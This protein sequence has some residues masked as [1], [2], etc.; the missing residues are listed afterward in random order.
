[1]AN[2]NKKKL[3]GS[4]VDE[5][6][7]STG[8]WPRY[9]VMTATDEGKTL[10]KLSPFAIHKGVKG[11]AGGDVTIKRQFGGDIYLTCCKKSQSDNLLK[12]VLFG[13]VAPVVVTQ[14]KSLNT[15]KGV[16]RN[17]ELARTDPDE[18]KENVPS[19]LDVQRIIIKR[20][21]MEVKTN[22]LL[23]L[24]S[25]KIPDS[26]K[27]CY[28]NI[29][30]T[31]YV[32]NPLRCYKCQ[33]FG[34]VT[35]KCK[36]NETCAKCSETGHKDDSCTKA[37][38]CIN[39]GESHAAYSKK[40]AIFK[41][42]FDIQSIRV[43]RNISFFEARTVYQQTHGQKVVN[44]A[45]A[46][47]V[48]TQTA[49]VC[50]QTD[51]S[52]VGPEPVTRRQRPAASVTNRPVPSVSR[53]VGTTTRVADV[54]KTAAPARSSPAKKG[55][56]SSK[57]SSPKQQ[58]APVPESD[59]YF[60]I[61]TNRGKVKENSPIT[62][63][64]ISPIKFKES[65][66]KKERL[67]RS[68]QASDF[69]PDVEISPSRSDLIKNKVKKVDKNIMFSEIHKQRPR[70]DDFFGDVPQCSNQTDV[71]LTSASDLETNVKSRGKVKKNIIRLPVD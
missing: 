36:H 69:L 29:P 28:L 44:Y 53:S 23:T 4:H 8:P 47:R 42:E 21:N 6:G 58:S 49:S 26:L 65:M 38:K 71:S 67:K 17:W 46:V 14:H 66:L 70:A 18:I 2:I 30:V 7:T 40:C 27:I 19:I 45:G 32:P 37:F 3:D 15:S 13:N 33:R 51:V 1:M 50:T 24:N 62:N 20:N 41:R 22:T 54:K 48:P 35:S 9:L 5:L 59:A 10:S 31:Q 57:P 39:C 16:V 60:T 43:S 34:H 55:E 61:K 68:Y 56:K 11:I 12:C 25:P 52:W 64:R 63:V